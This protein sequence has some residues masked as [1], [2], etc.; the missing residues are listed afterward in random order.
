MSQT[1]DSPYY[2]LY[3]QQPPFPQPDEQPP[4]TPP[5]VPPNTEVPLTVYGERLDASQQKRLWRR[6]STGWLMGSV[7]V[8]M[9]I[10]GI[11]AMGIAASYVGEVEATFLSM[12][13]LLA[14]LL[15]A[16]GRRRTYRAAARTRQRRQRTYETETS[17]GLTTVF[18]AD[19]VEQFSPLWGQTLPFSADV[20]YIEHEDFFTL[21]N[22]KQSVSLRADDLTSEQ[23]QQLYERICAVV[24]P[25]RQFADGR[26]RA[27]R[28]TPRPAPVAVPPTRVYDSLCA[29]RVAP[30]FSLPHG[31]IPWLLAISLVTASMLTA[32]FVV[33]PY[34]VA[35][36][37]LFL[38]VTFLPAAGVTVAWLYV[39][40]PRKPAG[41]VTLTFTGAGLLAEQ[42]GVQHFT[43]AADVRAA[44]T[45][46]GARLFTPSGVYRLCWNDTHSRQQV[47]WMLF[48]GR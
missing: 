8:L 23:A 30:S 46:N 47:E 3:T 48:G 5:P 2:R 33:T 39:H 6:R 24:P 35:D 1:P 16:S 11:S 42:N 27:T 45:E 22:G 37:L 32:L 19:R 9:G 4:L 13:L 7:L 36:F 26:F 12:M 31:V 34:F 25:E 18:Y 21:T 20:Q 14:A 17:G 29:E 43:A 10:F 38:L 15:A 40:T 44:R 41:A 28:Q